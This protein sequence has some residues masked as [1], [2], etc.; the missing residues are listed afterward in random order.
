MRL[1]KEEK[2]EA[3]D[4]ISNMEMFIVKIGTEIEFINKLFLTDWS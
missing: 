2:K 3:K 1:V 4:V